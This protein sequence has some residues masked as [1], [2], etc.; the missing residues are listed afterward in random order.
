MGQAFYYY[1]VCKYF[2]IQKVIHILYGKC[3]RAVEITPGHTDESVNTKLQVVVFFHLEI[4]EGNA[5]P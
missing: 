2:R 5:L 4:H 1:L 3:G